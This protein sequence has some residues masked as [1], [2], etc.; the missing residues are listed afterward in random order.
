MFILSYFVFLK[1][2]FNSVYSSL[3]LKL[4]WFSFNLLDA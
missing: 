2:F 3:N 4:S 1:A